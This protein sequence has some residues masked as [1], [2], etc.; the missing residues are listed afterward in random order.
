MLIRGATRADLPEILEIYNDVVRNTTAIYDEDISTLGQRLAWFD[1]RQRRGLPVLVAE[2]DR[3]VAGFSSFGDWRTRWGYRFTVEHSVHVRADL[4]G[5]GFGRALVEA[6]FPHAARLGMHMMIAQ[7]DSA[8]TASIRMHAKL[9][10][11]TVGT[12]KQVANKFDRWLD[13]I[14]MQRLVSPP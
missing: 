7:I 1:E 8:A 3:Q 12:F 4:R 11:E 2:I 14:A 13:L 9:G 5:N 6:L 10:F